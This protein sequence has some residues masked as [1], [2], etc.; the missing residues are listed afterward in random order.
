MDKKL[1]KVFDYLEWRGDL[2]FDT[3]PFNEVDAG[4][5][6]LLSYLDFT[7]LVPKE[8][9]GE[10]YSIKKI[11]SMYFGRALPPDIR[12]IDLLRACGKTRRFGDILTYGH[13]SKLD[14][15]EE[16][17]F[18]G[19]T[20]VLPSKKKKACIVF[21]G[22]D[23][24]LIGWKEDFNMIFTYPVPC[25]EEALLYLEKSTAAMKNF[26][27]CLAGHSKGGN[28]VIYASSLCSQKAFNR[29]ERIYTFDSP[30]FDKDLVDTTIFS[31]VNSKIKSFVP[32][33]SV[34]GMLME[35][36]SSYTVVESD[37]LGFMQ[38]DIFSWGIKCNSFFK[39]DCLTSFS[40]NV[41]KTMSKWLELLDLNQR[42]DFVNSLF[43][44]L[45]E[46]NIYEVRDFEKISF[47]TVVTALKS[48]SD[49]D[50]TSKECVLKAIGLFFKA[51][52]DKNDMDFE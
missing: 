11:D 25:Q 49:L 19:I 46:C 33:D 41:K 24:T 14:G 6:C 2:D 23:V 13:V 21:R 51:A 52:H 16:K 44:I 9:S 48:F 36:P 50:S 29:L 32:K 4:I 38:H 31:R 45:E 39:R 35:N 17:Q 1:N 30:G 10:T 20:F 8:F 37:A 5:L 28:A 42:R 43:R 18:C 34:I 12:V 27:L 22:T 47:S 15:E 7:G 26:E 3:S 40:V